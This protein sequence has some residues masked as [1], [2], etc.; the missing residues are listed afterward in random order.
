MTFTIDESLNGCTVKRFLYSTLS[1][2]SALVKKLKSTD[3]GILVNGEH[4]TVRY[5][6]KENDVISLA[7]DD[8]ESDISD[9]V[10]PA[11]IP[12]DIIYEDEH[13]V[14]LN[15]SAGMPTHPSHNHH[16]DTLANGLAYYFK[17]KSRP[18]VFRAVNRLD[19]DTS[20]VVLVAKSKHSAHLLSKAMIN[21][22]F[23]KTYTALI[24][25][26]LECDGEINLPIMRK[27]TSTMLRMV[28]TQ[29]TEHSKPSLTKYSIIKN[30]EAATLVSASPIS[31]RTHQLRVHFSH[32]GHPIFGDGLYGISDDGSDFPRLAL[33]CTSLEFT[34]PFTHERLTLSAPIP[35]LL[36]ETII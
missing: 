35:A 34:H 5:V 22:D 28:D 17:S 14:A 21:G 6:L 24:H 8:S 18:F 9:N 32:I 1:F 30:S 10:E 23:T 11:D 12:I 19:A 27:S 15:K 33:H 25:G 31:G 20:G 3:N 13:I 26:R 36:T 2:S 16:R 29:N 7:Y 4:V